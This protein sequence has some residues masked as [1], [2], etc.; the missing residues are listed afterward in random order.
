[1]SKIV[2]ALA[3]PIEIAA[4]EQGIGAIIDGRAGTG[5]IRPARRSP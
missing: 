2:D 1:V 4:P 3:L 5:S